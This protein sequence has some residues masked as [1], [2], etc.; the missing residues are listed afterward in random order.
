MKI[1]T[2]DTVKVVPPK[3]STVYRIVFLKGIFTK[4]S[5]DLNLETISYIFY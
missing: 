2:E 1:L 5:R 4:C 3:T